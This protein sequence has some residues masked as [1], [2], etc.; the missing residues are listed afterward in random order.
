VSRHEKL[1]RVPWRE[2]VRN[3]WDTL[4][5]TLLFVIFGVWGL[6]G[7]F[8]PQR[9][10]FSILGIGMTIFYVEMIGIGVLLLLALRLNSWEI[11]RRA[12]MIYA[13]ALGMLGV[14]L[15]LFN[16]SPFSILAIAF[17]MQGVVTVR[18]LG[19]QDKVFHL[20]QDFLSKMPDVIP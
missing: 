8:S 1:A 10:I 9:N 15:L 13:L 19:N 6:F 7:S 14:L 2:L 4:L 18:L 5:H 16:H 3:D 12:Y 20:A 11:R 17:A